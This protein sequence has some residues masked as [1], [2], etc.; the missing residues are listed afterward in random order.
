MNRPGRKEGQQAVPLKTFLEVVVKTV[1]NGG[2]VKMAADELGLTTASVSMR[3]KYLRDKGVKVPA[4]SASR[5]VNVADEANSI[6]AE[7]GVE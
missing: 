2:T 5:S 6:L 1:K 4:F 7:L 3:L